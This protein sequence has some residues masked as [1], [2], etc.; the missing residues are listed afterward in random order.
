MRLFS[1]GQSCLFLTA[2]LYSPHGVSAAAVPRDATNAMVND[3]ESIT[4][5]PDLQWI[6]CFQNFTCARLEVPLDYGNPTRGSTAIAFM[7]LAAQNVTENT[8]NIVINPGGPGGS[9]VEI[10]LANSIPFAE[11]I[12]AEHNVVGFDPRGVGF[13]GPNVDCWPSHPEARA[14]FEKLFY[15]D[16][17]YASS[18][19]LSH[20]FSAADFF[21]EAC[22]AAV[23]G[24][25]GSAAF[26]SS[27]AVARDLLAYTKAEQRAAGKPENEAKLSYYGISY[28]TVIGTTF[29]HLFP[30][31]VGPMILDGV[32]DVEDI[33]ELG[34]RQNLYDS[35]KAIDAF[36]KYCNEGGPQSCAFWGPT[37]A[38]IQHRLEKLLE[39]LKYNPIP[40]PSSPTCSIPLLATYSGLKELALQAVF[41]PLQGFPVLANVFASLEKGDAS[42]YMAAVT[43]GF[44]PSNPCNN[45][46]QGT[47]KDINTLIKCVD[48]YNSHS[49][50]TLDQYRSYVD[51][52]T[53]ESRFFGEVWPN[54]ANGVTCR[55]FHVHPPQSGILSGKDTAT[56]ILFVSNEIDPVTPR[57]GA[58][59]MSSVFRGSEVL[60][61]ASVGHT[62]IASVSKCL[63]QRA[64]A[65]FSHGQLPPHNTVCQ[66]DVVPFQSVTRSAKV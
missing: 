50:Q 25:N 30:E 51:S 64:Q 58:Y 7:K 5:S 31:N 6:P 15:S 62:A 44:L 65:Y 43:S 28:G 33:Y 16:T 21:G 11:V 9:G 24:S 52:L 1:L 23:G 10:L 60:I 47:T 46:T 40:V 22:T 38:S 55:S 32:L 53:A 36:Y 8:R 45:G 42:V 49:L 12:Q 18:T 2:A 20:Q 3:W 63:I 39:T 4:P 59:K 56:P 61:Q 57:R 41:I 26:V 29:A 17:S 27:P 48:G 35:D 34:W 54:N 37:P 19:S 66:P 13:S 14:Q